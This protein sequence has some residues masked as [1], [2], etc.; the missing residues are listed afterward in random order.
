[1]SGGY[2]AARHTFDPRRDAVWRAL[3]RHHFARGIGADDCVLDL[4]CGYGGFINHVTARRRIGLDVWP[5]MAA[6]LAPGVEP[7]VARLPDLAAVEDGSIDF[8]FASN[9]FEHLPQDDVAETLLALRAKLSPRGILTAMQPNYRYAAR[10]Y[11]D[12]YTHVSVWSHV[13]LADFL[14][15]HDYEVLQVV[16]RF[17]PL[18]L[19]T[20][21]LA[22]PALVRLYLA[23]P[24]KPFAGQMLIKARPRG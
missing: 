14:A 4:G 10:A 11:Y 5:G 8:A 24:F 23:A 1:V 19:K 13:G 18:T 22:S 20:W 7:I 15:A 17:L 12:D 2:H 6:Y 16:P 9:V 3:V 21:P